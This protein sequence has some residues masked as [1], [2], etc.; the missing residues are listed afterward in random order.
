MSFLCSQILYTWALSIRCVSYEPHLTCHAFHLLAPNTASYSL[1]C[2]FYWTGYPSRTI[3]CSGNLV[4][5]NRA[6]VIIGW[7]RKQKIEIHFSHLFWWGH[8]TVACVW[9]KGNYPW[10]HYLT[11]WIE[12]F[13]GKCTHLSTVSF[14]TCFNFNLLL[15]VLYWN[16]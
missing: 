10:S 3:V 7:M 16:Q 1:V 12:I 15:N 8:F 5:W 9:S 6:L 11:T 2:L 13:D 14:F 4:T